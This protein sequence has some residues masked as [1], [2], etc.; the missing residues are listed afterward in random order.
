MLAGVQPGTGQV[1]VMAVNRN[2]SN[3]TRTTARSSDPAKAARPASRA[4]TRTRRCRWSAAT[5]SNI[6]GYQFG[7]TFKMF[8][9]IAALQDGLPLSY[10]IN[11]TYK[12]ISERPSDTTRAAATA[13]TARTTR[14]RQ[15][16][17]RRTC[18][19]ASASRSTRYFVPLEDRMDDGDVQSARQ[20]AVERRQGLGI[21][22]HRHGCQ[23]VVDAFTLGVTPSIPLEM[24][25]AYATVD[26]DGMYCAP[27]PVISITDQQGQQARRRASRSATRRSTRTSRTPRSTRPAA[28]SAT[29]SAECSG[30]AH[31]RRTR[32]TSWAVAR[33]A[34]KTGTNDDGASRDALIAMTP[35]LAVAGDPGR[36]GLRRITDGGTPCEHE[37]DQQR[38]GAHPGAAMVKG[39]PKLDL[40][41]AAER[42]DRSA[43]ARRHPDVQVQLGRVR[44]E[45]ALRGQ[46]L[47]YIVMSTRDRLGLPGRHGRAAR[48]DRQHHRKARVVAL[49]LSNGKAP[50]PNPSGSPGLPGS[51][52]QGSRRRWRRRWRWRWR[53][54]A[55]AGVAAT[56]T[57]CRVCRRCSAHP[58]SRRHVDQPR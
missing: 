5:A 51:A 48:P 13:S 32:R 1:Q 27:T 54:A 35:Q 38:R 20:K 30:S 2:Y 8:T 49:Y 43:R 55:P 21:G 19:P 53:P 47:R 58:R 9:M 34:G 45:S 18:G 42:A 17:A 7:S 4:T 12:Y 52:R 44:R 33:S 22:V 15:S 40:A 24:A 41:R 31:R 25:A 28:R 14:R 39:K 23:P 26:D 37:R 11:A 56:A 46:G 50:T 3:D 29:R 10:T 16:T 57:S 6:D 36:P